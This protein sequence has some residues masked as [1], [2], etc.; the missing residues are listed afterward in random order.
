MYEI[1]TSI[2]IV[3]LESFKDAVELV[4]ASVTKQE[5]E[6]RGMISLTVESDDIRELFWLGRL[7]QNILNAIDRENDLKPKI[8]YELNELPV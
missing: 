2:K 7:F 1:K 4:R 5:K 6:D 3:E 8:R